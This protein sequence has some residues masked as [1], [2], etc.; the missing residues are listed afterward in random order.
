[1]LIGHHHHHH[2]LAV[3]IEDGQGISRREIVQKITKPTK[4]N[5][6][7]CDSKSIKKLRMFAPPTIPYGVRGRESFFEFPKSTES[8]TW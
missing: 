3:L 7:I 8:S 5:K 2:H 6:Q 1:M 4:I